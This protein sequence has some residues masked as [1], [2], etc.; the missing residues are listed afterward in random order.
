MTVEKKKEKRR[1]DIPLVMDGNLS[2]L[3]NAMSISRDEASELLTGS[4]SDPSKMQTI[5]KSMGVGAETAKGQS[6]EDLWDRA[7]RMMLLNWMSKMAGGGGGGDDMDKTIKTI[8]LLNA[9]K[10]SE[11]DWGTALATILTNQSANSAHLLDSVLKSQSAERISASNTEKEVATQEADQR[12]NA[13]HSSIAALSQNRDMA[14]TEK[15]KA[16]LGEFGEFVKLQNEM[17][18]LS[19]EMSGSSGGDNF[20]EKFFAGP[21]FQEI[22]KMAVEVLGG[23]V[24]K[25]LKPAS[26]IPD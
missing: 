5:R 22:M 8:A 9:T 14:P 3:A 20:T 17:I 26:G 13:I 18:R 21:Q 24:S 6:T 2:L 10:Q 25:P 12:L 16:M 7:E 15:L 11:G 4:I 19:K 1:T 23:A